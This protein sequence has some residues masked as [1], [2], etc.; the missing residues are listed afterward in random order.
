MEQAGQKSR[1]VWGRNPGELS[2]YIGW[3]VSRS[4]HTGKYSDIQNKKEP[5]YNPL[6]G[7][8][9]HRHAAHKKGDQG[10]A[11]TAP[12]GGATG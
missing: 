1:P 3:G 9:S 11:A 5:R 6:W 4:V 8:L 7:I 12:G 10:L 2:G